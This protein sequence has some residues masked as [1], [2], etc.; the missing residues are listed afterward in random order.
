MTEPATIIKAM[1]SQQ[2][3][4][5]AFPD[6]ATWKPWRVVLKSLFGLPMTEKEIDIFQA[7]TGRGAPSPR[8]Y[9]ESWFVCGRRSGKSRILAL[10][11]AYLATFRNWEPY[12]APGEYGRVM[13]VAANKAQ[14]R[15]IFDFM[16]GLLQESPLLSRMIL[17]ITADSIELQGRI[18]IEVHASSFRGIRGRTT[19]AALFDEVAF[20]E[21]GEHSAN[22]DQEVLAAIRPSMA[23]VPGSMLL[24]ASS[25]YSRQGV[26]WKAYDR[27]FG[28][29]ES[30]PLVWQAATRAM[31]PTVKQSFIDQQLAEDEAANRAEYLAEWR[32]DVESFVSLDVVRG[33]VAPYDVRHPDSSHRYVAFVDPAGGS[34]ADCFTCTIAHREKDQIHIDA[35]LSRKPHFSPSAVIDEFAAT[36]RN[37]RIG[38]VTGDRWGGEFPREAFR[39][40]D[41]RYEVA[42]KNKSELY[43]GLLPLLNSGRI[44]L[45]NH[46]K[47]IRQIVSL[48][49][50]VARS[51][52]ETIDHPVRGHD[53]EANAV[54]GAAELCVVQGM[55]VPAC[56][57][58]Y[59]GAVP[60]WAVNQ[61]GV[62]SKFD[63]ACE[64]GSGLE[65]GFGTSR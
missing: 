18:A 20:W 42:K 54:A 34:G 2:L 12:L 9:Q 31:N 25:P 19:V 38:V 43:Q 64:E 65:G 17:N 22:P 35:V 16:V 40:H 57:G 13:I 63:G 26:L 8:G 44:V 56:F 50:R 58:T 29:D 49:R 46:D 15:S 11:A 27:H 32:S 60:Y 3:F 52:R 24:C 62:R 1:D 21:S 30:L 39:R 14:A 10:V 7:H 55:A 5:H 33:C 53:D 37:Y 47:L 59:S 61:G 45:P 6:I 41:I 36:L 23:T 48:E 51:G 4:G 28:N